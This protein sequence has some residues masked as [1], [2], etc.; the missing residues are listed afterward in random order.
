[1]IHQRLEPTIEKTDYITPYRIVL[2][3]RKKSETLKIANCCYVYMNL[4]IT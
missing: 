3:K 4:E 2:K 1:M